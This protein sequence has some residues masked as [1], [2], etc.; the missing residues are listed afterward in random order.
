MLSEVKVDEPSLQT[1][2]SIR[3]SYLGR[4]KSRINQ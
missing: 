1:T 4:L 2:T 3:E